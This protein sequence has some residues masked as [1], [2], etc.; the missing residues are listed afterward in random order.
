MNKNIPPDRPDR[1]NGA[2]RLFIMALVLA[3]AATAAWPPLTGALMAESRAFRKLMDYKPAKNHAVT[4]QDGFLTEAAYSAALDTGALERYKEILNETVSPQAELLDDIFNFKPLLIPLGLGRIY[5]EPPVVVSSTYGVSVDPEAYARGQGLMY[6]LARQG[7][8]LS[9]CSTWRNYLYAPLAALNG[10]EE[11][12]PSLT[13]RRK[14]ERILWRQ[15]VERGWR[16]GRTK[17]DELFRQSV[18]LLARDYIGLLTF[19]ELKQK[20]LIK[21]PDVFRSLTP[22]RVR[23]RAVLWDEE[24]FWLAEPGRF[25]EKPPEKGSGPRKPKLNPPAGRRAANPAGPGE[26]PAPARSAEPVPGRPP[27]ASAHAPDPAADLRGV[28]SRTKTDGPDRTPPDSP[29]PRA[30]IIPLQVRNSARAPAGSSAP[31]RD[32]TA[33]ELL[34]R[35]ADLEAVISALKSLSDLNPYSDSDRKE[36]P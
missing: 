4:V 33:G 22:F 16:Q 29:S 35:P 15:E 5:L 28:L 14:S 25:L 26:E 23:D 6:A 7:R 10:P 12:H 31:G 36:K 34:T 27:A 1:R 20:G 3:L 18:A 32:R 8:F 13:P 2:A 24:S 30:R 21:E 11:I 17:A 9:E 19:W